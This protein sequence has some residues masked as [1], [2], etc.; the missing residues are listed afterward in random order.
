MNSDPL[1]ESTPR[2]GNGIVAAMSI[3]GGE[4]AFAGLVGHASGSRSSRWRCR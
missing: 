4:H 1:S 2:I 3:E